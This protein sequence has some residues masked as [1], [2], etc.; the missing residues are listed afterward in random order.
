VNAVREDPKR[1]GL[2]FAATEKAVWVSFDDGAHWQSLKLNLPTTP[3]HDMVIHG[4][5]LV[6]ATHGRA[7]W[8]LDDISPLRAVSQEVAASGAFLFPPAPALRFRGGRGRRT[9]NEAD[10]PPAGAI[11]YYYLK[12][13]AK[14]PITLEI[15]DNR[16]N[17]IR[18][19]SSKQPKK[20][21]NADEEEPDEGEAIPPEEVLPSGAGMHRFVWD[22]R[23]QMP[24]LVSSAIWDM[25]KPGAPLALPGA[26]EVRLTAAGKTLSAPIEVKPDP[27]VNVPR[28]DLEEQLALWLKTRDLLGD[29]HRAVLDI[30]AVRPQLLSL[31]KHLNAAADEK[32]KAL[33]AAVDAIRKKMDAAEAELIEVKAKSS[34]DMC[35]YPTKLHNKVAWLMSSIG[36]GDSA[37]A[38]SEQEFYEEKRRESDAQIDAW[39]KLLA[40][41]I[42]ALNQKIRGEDIPV[43]QLPSS[44]AGSSAAEGDDRD[45]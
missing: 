39:K 4:D 21:A 45:N 30:R 24:P 8:V 41:D 17:V 27:R 28:A 9:P 34:E 35:N 14:E 18:H 37:P 11:L 38:A 32:Q 10:N 42:P 2:L 25:G 22:M 12:A 5:D 1:R 43:I 44:K 20:E 23:Y 26:Y 31:R 15:L 13:E 6:V 3:V 7:F 40:E 19:Y 16:K 33:A 36:G 29:I